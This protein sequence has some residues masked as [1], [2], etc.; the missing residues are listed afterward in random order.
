MTDYI[1][2]RRAPR[3][4]ADF[5]ISLT[6]RGQARE[7]T[8]RDI[9]R[10][11]LMC[12]YPEA[13]AEMTMVEIKLQIPGDDEEHTTKGTIVWCSKRRGENPPAYD[14]GVFFDRLPRATQEALDRYVTVKLALLG[15]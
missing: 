14:L 7:A 15:P 2:K 9:S 10:S 13:I 5:A 12:S 6:D 11:G 4:M 1:E 3:A 8:V